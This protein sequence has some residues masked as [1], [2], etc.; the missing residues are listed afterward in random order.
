MLKILEDIQPLVDTNTTGIGYFVQ[1]LSLHLAEIDDAELTGYS[2]GRT[3]GPLDMSKYIRPTVLKKIINYSRY[4]SIE[5]PIELFFSTKNI[6]ILLG[7]NY[8]IPSSLK[9]LPKI[10]T[11]HDLCYV[12]HPEW[13]Q[14]RNG[15]IL[16]KMV[17][18]T[19]KRASGI[20]AISDF[21]AERIRQVYGY[22]GP[23]LVIDIPP[24]LSKEVAT[25]PGGL[26]VENGK[27]FLFISTIEPRKNISTLLDAYEALPAEIQAT[28][29]LILAGKP[30]WDSEVLVRLTSGGN[31]N[32]RYIGYINESERNWLYAN[33]TA[34][35]VPSHYEGFGMMTLESLIAGAP[36]ITSDIPPQ[37]E[38][39]G[40]SGTYFKPVDVEKLTELL[41]KYTDA[42]FRSSTLKNQSVVLK[43]Y[44]WQK[45]AECVFEFL[46]GVVGK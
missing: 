46:Q 25:K 35:V 31:R 5:L 3:K 8:L 15:Y 30:G 21:T 18:K 16:R 7:T 20:I 11:I 1:Q 42:S 23:I 6:E 37:R 28:Y 44:S 41:I 33:A 14:G 17:P 45:T 4:I 39:L 2:F 38:I 32:I 36:V 27:Y 10:A 9:Q 26:S 24:K 22:K 34:T 13:V 29:P 19:L 40:N 43:N 12:D